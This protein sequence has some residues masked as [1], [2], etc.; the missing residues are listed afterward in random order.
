M[1]NNTGCTSPGNFWLRQL[2]YCLGEIE[3]AETKH[4][5]REL[6]DEIDYAQLQ[7]Q[8][9]ENGTYEK[10]EIVHELLEIRLNE[11]QD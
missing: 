9:I 8:A 1:S 2:E 10:P 4:E 11:E 6:Q 3:S 5:Q 7:L